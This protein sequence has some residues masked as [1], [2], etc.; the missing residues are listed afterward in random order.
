MKLFLHYF[1]GFVRSVFQQML[2][3]IHELMYPGQTHVHG[4]DRWMNAWERCLMFRPTHRGFLLAPGKRLSLKDTD[5]G[6]LIVAP[7]GGGKSTNLIIPAILEEEHSSFIVTDPSGE[8]FALSSGH[9][10]AKGFE[11]QL[12]DTEDLSRSFS[13]NPFD[14]IHSITDAKKIADILIS[15][16]Y[17]DAGGDST[18][19]NS[20]ASNILFMLIRLLLEQPYQYRN[21]HNLKY[22]LDR[23]G[24]TGEEIMPLVAAHSDPLL[25]TEMKSFISQTDKIRQGQLSSAKVALEKFVDPKLCRLCSGQGNSIN[26]KSLRQKPTAIFLCS[27]EDKIP[28]LSMLYRIFY[29]QVFEEL[30]RTPTEEERHITL[31]LDE[32]ANLG[33]LTNLEQYATTLRKRRAAIIAVVQSIS[34][35]EAV[36]G[37]KQAET[38]I[39]GGLNSH[40]LF[41]GL[42]HDTCEKVSKTLGNS[43]A[44]YRQNSRTVTQARP[45]LT[46]TEIRTMPPRQALLLSGNKKPLAFRMTP[47]FKN[48]RQMAMTKAG[49]L[50]F[51]NGL[52]QVQLEYL[53]LGRP[54]QKKSLEDVMDGIEF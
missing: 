12:W 3:I 34:Q 29:Q 31:Y 15:S 46:A 50:S 27:R 53:P 43:T 24:A 54:P 48:A 38:I 10:Q 39:G 20:G 26:I 42:D 17:P 19:W 41:P 6:V 14:A 4:T 30:M 11:V 21:F 36:Y 35:I 7:V 22:L 32:F 1:T 45:L 9:L 47:Y 13:W 2:H 25:V 23:F 8:I 33:K 49:A 18:F 40:I 5:R 44:H 28:R 51:E 52:D 37:K 16:A